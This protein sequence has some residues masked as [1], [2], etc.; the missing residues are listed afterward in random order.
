[1]KILLVE[2]D[3]S[4]VYSLKKTLTQD[5]YD[6]IA[7]FSVRDALVHLDQS[8]D[9]FLID[10]GLPDGDGISLARTIREH[11]TQGIIFI[12][13]KDDENTISS[14]F[15]L[16]GD[17]YITKPFR[18]SELKQRIQSVLKR[19]IISK[20]SL[21]IDPM[22][23]KVKVDSNDIDLSVLEYRL[24]LHLIQNEGKVLTRESI[25][26]YL[27]GDYVTGNTLSVT[28]K[29]LRHKLGESVSITTVHT[30]GYVFKI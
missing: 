18:I 7:A 4:I 24:L 19:S 2:D 23:A 5:G 25:S 9:L 6:V 16:G 22:S 27:W 17:D 10:I 13:A 21:V 20:G 8:F 3:H 11:H 15:D 30:K 14:G 28:M 12:S 26:K 29:R 1:M